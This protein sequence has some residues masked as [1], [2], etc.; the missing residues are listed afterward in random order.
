M[1]LQRALR[2]KN[3]DPGRIM[4]CEI[5]TGLVNDPNGLFGLLE[6]IASAG[7]V[8]RVR[9]VHL[10]ARPLPFAHRAWHSATV[11]H[12]PPPSSQKRNLVGSEP[13]TAYPTAPVPSLQIARG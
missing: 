1:K 6:R 11:A 10:D 4:L 12:D 2:G 3:E 8:G 5:L 9:A 7:S 13:G